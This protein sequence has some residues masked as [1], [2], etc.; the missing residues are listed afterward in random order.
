MDK[1]IKIKTILFVCASVIISLGAS[2]Q[3]YEK[4]STDF[5]FIIQT[6]ENRNSIVLE[7]KSGCTWTNLMFSLEDEETKYV[8]NSGVY[9][10]NYFESQ[11][12]LKM[13]NPLQVEKT[14]IIAF[15]KEGG[16]IKLTGH[17]GTRWE[18]L[19][20]KCKK[21]YCKVLVTQDEIKEL[22]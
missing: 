1:K 20:F 11:K 17:K 3:F 18:K 22:N 8:D 15:K 7:C 10:D 19:G 12:K 9:L 16:E 21:Q 14:F 4:K 2:P 5:K 13:P 6:T